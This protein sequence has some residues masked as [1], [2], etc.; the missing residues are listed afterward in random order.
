MEIVTKEK[1]VLC[2]DEL[3]N[4]E[5][6]RPSNSALYYIKTD[7]DGSHGIL[8]ESQVLLEDSYVNLQNLDW[9]KYEELILCVN[10]TDGEAVLF[11]KDITVVR[12]TNATL[13]IE[14]N[15]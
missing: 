6:F 7:I 12:P 11:H 15:E 3:S 5:V 2:L 14:E 8:T 4:G 1:K 13:E 9:D 10:L